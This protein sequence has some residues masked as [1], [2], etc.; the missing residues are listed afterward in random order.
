MT[1]IVLMTFSSTNCF[2]RDNL[3][4]VKFA[5]DRTIFGGEAAA[6]F[7]GAEN[8]EEPP[9]PDG[10]IP[11]LPV[12]LKKAGQLAFDLILAVSGLIN[13]GYGIFLL[14]NEF[15][16]FINGTNNIKVCLNP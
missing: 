1:L 16:S 15:V 3:N 9:V 4:D 6:L 5:E 13:D 11:P 2:V 7:F 12:L 8:N 14:S 10:M